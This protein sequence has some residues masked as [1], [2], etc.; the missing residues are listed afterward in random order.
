VGR[1][2]ALRCAPEC[3][4]DALFCLYFRA[5]CAAEGVCC[6][7]DVVFSDL[8]PET[9]YSPV[10]LKWAWYDNIKL[11]PQVHPLS[12]RGHM[13]HVRTCWGSAEQGRGEGGEDGGSGHG[14]HARMVPW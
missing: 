5:A 3:G 8:F 2:R 13:R 4:C 10:Y 12:A 6:Y 11:D 14:T 7:G 9:A 1:L